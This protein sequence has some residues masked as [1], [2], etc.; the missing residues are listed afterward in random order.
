[1]KFRDIQM[2]IARLSM[3]EN[4]QPLI[5]ALRDL[6]Q[7]RGG[8]WLKYS[9]K[10]VNW[11]NDTTQKPFFTVFAEGNVKLPFFAFSVLPIVT[12]PG[13]GGCADFCY[14][15][16]AWRY[17]SAFF[18]QV[19]N[20]V[21]VLEQNTHLDSAFLSLKQ[22]TTVRLY[23]DGDFDSIETVRYWFALCNKRSDLAVYGYSKSWFELL[24]VPK[25]ELP[26]N[27]KLNLSSGSNHSEGTRD[28]VQDLS[29]TRGEFI[30]VNIPKVLQGKY[31]TPEYK[32][33]VREGGQ[34]IG[35]EKAF[36]CPGRCGTCTKTEHAC[37][38][39][40]FQGIPVLIG[41]H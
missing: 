24:A 29:I 20:T 35:I 31:S 2:H 13:A 38:S 16:K 37:G 17:P 1:M 25:D 14:S 22:N 6:G 36:V 21:M 40:R 5:N 39:D 32:Q 33:A 12:C 18:R 28:A 10:L 26:N 19:Q 8:H 4:K 34:A 41:I 27:Y 11:L 23:V 30:A 15:L 7:N 3:L 9:D